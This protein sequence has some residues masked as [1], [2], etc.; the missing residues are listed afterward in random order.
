LI[1]EMNLWFWI[2]PF[3]FALILFAVEASALVEAVKNSKD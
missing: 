1:G 2:A 3:F